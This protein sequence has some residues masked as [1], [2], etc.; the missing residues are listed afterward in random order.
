MLSTSYGK[1]FSSSYNKFG[2]TPLHCAVECGN[3]KLV[4]A[5]HGS[6]LCMQSITCSCVQKLVQSG[7]IITAEDHNHNTPLHIACQNGHLKVVKFLMENT[8]VDW[9]AKYVFTLLMLS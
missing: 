1:T 7:A 2:F 3:F 5:A 4:Y 8:G 9:E 6:T